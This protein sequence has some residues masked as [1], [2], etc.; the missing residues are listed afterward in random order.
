MKIEYERF[1]HKE[2]FTELFS[3]IDFLTMVEEAIVTYEE[4]KKWILESEEENDSEI[5]D[6]ESLNTHLRRHLC[7]I[8]EILLRN[9]EN[10]L[11][12]SVAD[13]L[14]AI[15]PEA[16]SYSFL[17][18]F[19]FRTGDSLFRDLEYAKKAFELEPN[20]ITYASSLRAIS[21]AI[22]EKKTLNS[23]VR[24]E[25]KSIIKRVEREYPSLA[26]MPTQS[27]RIKSGDKIFLLDLH[28]IDLEKE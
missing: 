8:Y 10:D 12:R 13:R 4:E 20:H 7:M 9:G 6:T 22:L 14:L 26:Q 15:L 24:E 25:L 18:S 11:A 3:N 19:G 27:F 21:L 16:E 2:M 5:S 1:Y 17:A 23:S 28:R